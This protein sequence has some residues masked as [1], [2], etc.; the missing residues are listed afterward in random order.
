M[1]R[2]ANGSGNATW[3]FLEQYVKADMQY[4]TQFV[5]ALLVALCPIFFPHN[6]IGRI[7]SHPCPCQ[8]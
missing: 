6:V 4:V 8:D 1:P 3:L 5:A 2:H 7:Q